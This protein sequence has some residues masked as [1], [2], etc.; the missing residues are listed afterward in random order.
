MDRVGCTKTAAILAPTGKSITARPC[1]LNAF[2][3]NLNL[4]DA[5][6]IINPLP[7]PWGPFRR[8]WLIRPIASLQPGNYHIQLQRKRRQPDFAP[9]RF[10]RSSRNP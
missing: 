4:P 8:P 9:K 10:Q 1:N 3:L 6:Q 2:W 5:R 7:A